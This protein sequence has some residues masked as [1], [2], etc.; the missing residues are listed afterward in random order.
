MKRKNRLLTLVFLLTVILPLSPGIVLG[1]DDKV[2]TLSK[3]N[4]DLRNRVDVLENQLILMNEKLNAIRDQIAQNRVSAAAAVSD[5]AAVSEVKPEVKAEVKPEAKPEAPKAP[6]KPSLKTKYGVDLYGY[7]K[8]DSVWDSGRMEVGNYAKWVN[9]QSKT[10]NDKMYSLTANQTRLGLKFNGPQPGN[11]KV[12]GNLELEGYGPNGTENKG[13]MGI[14][15]AFFQVEW[16]KNDFAMLCGQ[17]WDVI[18]PLLPNTINYSVAWWAG[19][20]G[21]RRPQFRLTKGIKVGEKAKLTF[22][23]AAARVV[24]DV[25]P[26][27]RRTGDTG[28]DSGQPSFQGRVALSLP[29][30]DKRTATLGFSGHNA[31]EEYDFNAAG[32]SK[33]IPSRSVNWDLTLPI[34]KWLG[35]KGEA[36][37]GQNVDDYF[38]GIGQGIVVTSVGS[39]TVVNATAFGGAFQKAEAVESRGG[40]LEANF[41][42]FEKWQFNLGFSVD[43]PS[44]NDLPATGRTKNNSRWFTAMH[45]LNEAVQL[46]LEI[47]RWKT[48]YKNG[49]NGD[50]SRVQTSCTYKF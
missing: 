39:G 47:S 23:A 3:E 50:D 21:A 31:N 15:H 4:A 44:D 29:C 10:G 5:A 36:W 16:P 49:T 37:S 13:N 17:T 43:N 7:V 30:F 2:E 12:T 9:P 19:N 38:G 8:L 24:G 45:D 42:P 22:Q 11:A 32:N 34:C 33:R 46:G 25:G 28:E 20:I 27:S 41:G 1:Q 40:W 18:S 35:V 14:R 6:E 48:N 26:F